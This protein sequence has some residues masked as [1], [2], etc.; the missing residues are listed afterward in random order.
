MEMSESSS[1][2]QAHP[3]ESA[4]IDG[5]AA[6]VILQTAITGVR[7]HQEIFSLTI[8]AHSFVTACKKETQK[9]IKIRNPI[10]II[11]ILTWEK[12]R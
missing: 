7:E 6:E 3:T 4:P 11:K 1:N 12:A 8:E 10:N 5:V 2:A 9:E